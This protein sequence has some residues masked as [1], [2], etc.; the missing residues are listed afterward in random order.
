MSGRE[1]ADAA[2]DPNLTDQAPFGQPPIRPD[3][4]KHNKTCQNTIKSARRAAMRAVSQ[5]FRGK[6]HTFPTPVPTG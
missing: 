2:R 4:P 6:N 3:V 1:P 5:A